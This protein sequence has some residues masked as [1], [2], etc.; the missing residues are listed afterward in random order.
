[1]DLAARR[2]IPDHLEHHHPAVL[3]TA[4][5]L[6]VREAALIDVASTEALEL[7]FDIA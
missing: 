5:R 7:I 3:A 6:G 4:E 2:L 1:V